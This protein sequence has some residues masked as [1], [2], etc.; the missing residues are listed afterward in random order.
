MKILYIILMFISLSLSQDRGYIF[1]TGSPDSTLGYLIDPNN[2]VANRFTIHSDYVLEAIGFFISAEN[3]ESSNITISIREDNN[4]IPGN[5]VSDLSIW[6]HQVNLLNQTN[7]NLIITTDLCIYLNKNNYYWWTIEAADDSTNATWIHS[8]YAFYNTATSND[9]G[10]SWEYNLGYAGAG[11]IFAEQVYESDAII[12]DINSDFTA[13]VIDVVALVGYILG[14]ANLNEEQINAA[15]INNDNS[16]DIVDVVALV[17][18]IIVPSEQSPVFILEDINPA[19]EY[20]SINIGPSF[21]SG[22][23]SCYYFGK[24]G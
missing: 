22:Q 4:G 17:N 19:S 12:G 11:A 15:D 21:F 3:I 16:I 20:Y 5:L 18:L 1:N 23:V 2:A 9:G 6:E 14:D 10:N 8:N 24:Q 7:Y 13:N